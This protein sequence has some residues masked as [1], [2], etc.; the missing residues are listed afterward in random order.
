MT[1]VYNKTTFNSFL[2][3][4]VFHKNIILIM[5]SNTSKE[6]I[7]QIDP[8]YLRQ[9]RV[10]TYYKMITPLVAQWMRLPKPSTHIYL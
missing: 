3:D 1:S 7:D 5:T 9:G 10:N 4:M 2:D 6:K 8:S